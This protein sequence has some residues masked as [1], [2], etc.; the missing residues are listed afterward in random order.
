[1]ILTKE[2]KKQHFHGDDLVDIDYEK[3][4]VIFGVCLKKCKS[5][6]TSTHEDSKITVGFKKN[7][8]N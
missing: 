5:V 2:T 3:R 1:M 4:W 6:I 7:E 8:N